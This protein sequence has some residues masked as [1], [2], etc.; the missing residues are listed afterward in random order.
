MVKRLLT[1]ATH[2]IYSLPIVVLM[3]HSSCNCRCVMCD[4]W[5]ANNEK[6][7]ISI[8]TLDKN[9]DA[10]RKL[11]VRE[12]VLSGGEALM[13]SNLWKFCDILR[14]NN[15]GVTLLSTGLL[16][17][18]YAADIVRYID[19]VIISIDG[20]EK[21]HDKIRNIPQ[22]FSKM[23]DGIAQLRKI[24]S[25]FPLTGRCVLQRG[26]YFDF[27]SIV[28]ESKAIGLDQIS[29][30]AADVSSSA[31][32]HP[33]GWTNDKVHQIALSGPEVLEFD[34]LVH[35][36]FIDLRDEY[37]TGF[38]AESPSRMQRIVQYYKA[39]NGEGHYPPGTCNAPWVSAVIESDG[40]VAPCF[41]HKPYGNIHDAGFMDVINSR[42]AIAFRRNLN[43]AVDDIC[44]KCVCSLKLR[45]HQLV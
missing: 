24:D 2:R 7:E 34:R 32:N 5:K 40:S 4:I 13:H 31:F 21:I 37:S 28:K 10:F 45:P 18:R 25:H 12:V 23:S 35:Q 15:I 33:G 1:L 8:E 27:Y 44:R 17:S 29:F 26:N 3:P 42:E 19:K 38:I 9:V 39:I 43:I 36:S 11:N 16:L 6:K 30:L 41:F 22:A 14:K 20:S